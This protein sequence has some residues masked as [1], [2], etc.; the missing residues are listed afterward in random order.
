MNREAMAIS[1]FKKNISARLTRGSFTWNV[2]VLAGG[3]AL[4][5]AISVLAS[6]ILTRLYTPDDFGV[7]AVYS[8]I[9]GILSV[10]ASW[11]YELAIPLPERDEE[12]VNLVALSLGIV[13][14]MSCGVGIGMWFLGNQIVQWVNAPTLRSYLWLIPIGVL[15]V[16]SYQVFN[17]W[18]VRQQAFEAIAKT[19]FNQGLAATLAQIVG[20]FLQDGP[21]GLIV[22]QIVGQCAGLVTLARLVRSVGKA[23]LETIG[24][25]NLK[26][27]AHRYRK[28]PCLSNFSGLINSAGLQIP[29]ILLAALYGAQVAGWFALAQRVLGTPMSLVGQAIAH[30]YMGTGS[31]LVY[32]DVK[33]L[34][35]LFLKT[36]ARLVLIGSIPLG[37]LAIAGPGLF[38]RVFGSNWENAGRYVQILCMAS[39]AQFVIVPLSQTVNILER[40]DWQLKWD[41]FRLLLVSLSIVLTSVAGGTH[42][43]AILSYNVSLVITYGIMFLLNLMLLNQVTINQGAC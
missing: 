4:G 13:V 23:K 33:A 10:V 14:L 35:S 17:Y 8:S 30:V 6:P 9:L 20:G 36:A 15:M 12:A 31:R 5:Q 29:T 24:W 39:L 37:I 34:R 25:E 16:G 43:Q 3:T 1:W 18:A 2:T 26:R 22:G 38:T 19:R 21:M 27:M 40:Q 11:R 42:W 28:F 32:K 41:I 7:L